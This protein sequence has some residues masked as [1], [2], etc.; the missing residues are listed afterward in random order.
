M[1]ENKFVVMSRN[2]AEATNNVL[3]PY[4][5]NKKNKG[6]QEQYQSASANT[7]KAVSEISDSVVIL[8]SQ[9]NEN[10][11]E[12]LTA[13]EQIT[14]NIASAANAVG[15]NIQPLMIMLNDDGEIINEESDIQENLTLVVDNNAAL[16]SRYPILDML[17]QAIRNNNLDVIFTE[18]PNMNGYIMGEVS[19]NGVPNTQ[20][21]FTV[22][23]EGNFMSPDKKIFIPNVKGN[24]PIAIELLNLKRFTTIMSKKHINDDMSIF[25]L[26][27]KEDKE[28]NKL[29]SLASLPEVVDSENR[30]RVITIVLKD[31]FQTALTNAKKSDPEVYFAFSEY[32]SPDSFKLVSV[33]PDKP[34]NIV[35]NGKTAVLNTAF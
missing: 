18:T 26:Y 11:N 24:T 13:A 14:I 12:T 34:M 3:I 23:L 20:L 7:H 25:D 4:N 29:I 31:G 28:I 35:Y 21:S 30:T 19:E 1:E 5:L 32:K 33:N 17:Q 6:Q 8:Q 27:T 22:D 10:N 16:I 9:D 15:L 2:I